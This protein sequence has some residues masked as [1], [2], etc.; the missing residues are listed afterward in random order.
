M[1]PRLFLLLVAMFFWGQAAMAQGTPEPRLALLIG[2]AA[3]KSSPLRNPV[4]D[5]RLMESVLKESGFTV[6]K[7]ENASMRDMRRLVREFGDRLKESGGVGLFYFAGHGVQVRGENF[8]ISTDSDIR[9]EDEV[10]DDGL[11]ASMV[12]EKMQTAGNRVNLVILDACRNN[13][14]PSKSRAAPD[15][16]AGMRAPGG[17]LVAYATAPGSV[18]SDGPGRNGLYTENLARAIRQPGLPVEEVF[19]Q[20]RTA[21]R[22]Q[23]NNQ[24]T[25]WENTALEGQFAFNG[26][27]ASSSRPDIA[28]LDLAFWESIKTSNY[29]ADFQAYLSQYPNGL[30]ANLAKGRLVQL[31]TAGPLTASASG[32]NLLG[33]LDLTDSF[34][35]LKRKLDVT[36]TGASGAKRVY[37]T[38]DVISDKGEV[39]QVRVGEHVLRVTSGA[40]WTVP[41]KDQASSGQASVEQ[42]DIGYSA[43]GTFSWT[44]TPVGQGRVRVDATVWYSSPSPH[45]AA[46]VYMYGK[47]SSTYS[48]GRELADSSVSQLRSEYPIFTNIMTTEL[49]FR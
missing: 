17:S 41:L 24:Q 15:G 12:L 23:S 38:G 33:T 13:P 40:L 9:N 11:N 37:S 36:A 42:I 19:K 10:A 43:Y 45:N 44:A 27:P 31:K 48:A 5:V 7:A 3:Y 18:A 2:N 14:F 49:K 32:S 35:G 29:P 8:L 26:Q 21:V 34:S 4:N 6:M 25:P 22:K 30:F 39:L 47:W 16:L 20:V 1:T 46:R 28:T